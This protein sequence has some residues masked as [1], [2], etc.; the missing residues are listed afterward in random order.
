NIYAKA[1]GIDVK[2]IDVGVDHSFE[3]TLD[4]W[5]HRGSK[6]INRKQAFG[7][8]NFQEYPAI[9]TAELHASM[10]VGMEMVDKERKTGCNV[11]GFGELS[12][13]AK[14]S[15][16]CTAVA[17]LDTSLPE[18]LPNQPEELVSYLDKALKIHP[19]S[20]DV[21]TI[22]SIYGG[23]DMGAMVAAIIRAAQIGRASC[24][25]RR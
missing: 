23:Y 7:S 8:R 3:G 20:H 14:F 2:A 12:R 9:T 10:Q 21:Y 13:G 4:Y 17:L 5:I 18:L 1:S 19:K 25:Q 16:W 15:A 6:L 24:R 11:I 22:L